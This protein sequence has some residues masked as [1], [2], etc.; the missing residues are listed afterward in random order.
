MPI[1]HSSPLF[2]TYLDAS[3]AFDRANFY[4]LFDKL[5]DRCVPAIYVRLLMFWYT[6]Q[7][8]SVKWGC[9]FSSSFLV[10]NGV[11][12][13]GVLSPVL[14]NIYMDDLSVVLKCY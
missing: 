4:K 13:G 10:G 6:H 1:N 5:L 14:F 12:Q 11:G 3:K 7:E 8:F 9:T 2:V